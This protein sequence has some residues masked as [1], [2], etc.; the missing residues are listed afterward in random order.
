MKIKNL[1]MIS[2]KRPLGESRQG[3][4]PQIALALG[5]SLFGAFTAFGIAPGTLMETVKIRP[6]MAELPLPAFNEDQSDD[7][8]FTRQGKVEQG[9]TVAGLLARLEVEDADALKFLRT[10]RTGK[11]IFQLKP[12][13]TVQAVATSSGELISLR[14]YNQ[15]DSVLVVEREGEGFV[16]AEKPLVETPGLV[17][18]TGII[19]NSLFAATDDAG[20]PDTVAIQLAKIFS[21]DIDFHDDLR[22][23]DQFSVIYEAIHEAGGPVRPGRVLAAEFIN[24]GTPYRAVYFESTPG[25]GDYYTP[26]GKNLRKAFLRSPLEFSRISSGFTMA[27]FHPILKNWRAH[28]GVDFAAPKGTRVL[29]TASGTVIF[30]GV[31]NGY[32]NV[33]EIRHQAE[34]STLYAHL[35]G[36]AQGVRN[37]AS[38]KQGDVIGYVGATGLAT[39]PHLHYEFKVAGVFRD[40]MSVAVP[41]AIPL[42]PQYQKAFTRTADS[43]QAKLTS[44]RGS[45]FSLFE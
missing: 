5:V 33:V 40:P 19:R 28:T 1:R 35:A 25:E 24:N 23:G 36:F 4:L 34:Y 37:G 9:D 14:Y 15:Q 18:K 3:W 6:V 20:I 39:G 43:M 29:A 32:G 10:D 7:A 31:K 42:L 30:A 12:G 22:R 26:D 21:T 11:A 17:F 45:D 41:R 27:R 2:Q 8:S 16:A 13:R 44:I 38:V